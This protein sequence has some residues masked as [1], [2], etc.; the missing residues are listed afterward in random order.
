MVI[1]KVSLVV[2]NFL[3]VRKMRMSQTEEGVCSKV[4]NTKKTV[5]NHCGWCAEAHERLVRKHQ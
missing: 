3:E 4:R 1:L 5:G 2:R